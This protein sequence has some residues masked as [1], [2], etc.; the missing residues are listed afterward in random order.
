MNVYSQNNN[1]LFLTPLEDII[2][3]CFNQCDSKKLVHDYIIK[4]ANFSFSH[5]RIIV[6]KNGIEKYS[7]TIYD[8]LANYEQPKVKKSSN[9][10]KTNNNEITF[11]DGALSCEGDSNFSCAQWNENR[12]L[13]I[14]SK[15]LNEVE[16][17]ITITQKMLDS[18]EY[19]A[20]FIAGMLAITPSA[21]FGQLL[22]VFAVNVISKKIALR[23][24]NTV[25]V[26]LGIELTGIIK[27]ML[28]DG[29]K[30]GDVI[31]LQGGKVT[32]VIRAGSGSNGGAGGVSGGGFGG[33]NI[34]QGL[35]LADMFANLGQVVLVCK[36]VY[37]KTADG[38][39]IPQQICY[40]Q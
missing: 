25:S 35:T 26:A 38:D 40:F 8:F 17:S 22:T 24:S 23:I 29:L 7:T 36:I 34:N 3:E 33:G 16:F 2:L 20:S 4:R 32:K 9:R 11:F 15:Y 1:D 5:Q 30:V 28:N 14:L 39:L 13:A 12:D 27:D 18:N 19:A 6:Q 31:N 21:K 37:T 10:I